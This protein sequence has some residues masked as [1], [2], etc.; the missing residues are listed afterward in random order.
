MA[1]LSA[2]TFLGPRGLTL[3]RVTSSTMHRRRFVV[4]LAALCALCFLTTRTPARGDQPLIQ[5]DTAFVSAA[6]DG[7]GWTIGNDLIRYALRLQGSTL[8]VQSIQDAQSGREWLRATGPDSFVIINALRV[9]IG[10]SDT[11]F[12]GAD[13]A[14]YQGGV[15][16]NL[17][18]RFT[19]TGLDITRSYVCYPG[20][21]VIETWT[22]FANLVTRPVVL[23]GLTNYSLAVENGTLHWLRGLNVPDAEGGSFSLAG[24][25]LD[26]GQIF[27][28][29]ADRR[30]SEQCVPWFGI[31]AEGTQ[32]FGAI[33][34]NGS[35]HLQVQRQGDHINVQ[36][37]LPVF[38][39]TVGGGA[40]MDTPHAIVGL[41]N[42][43]VPEVSMALRRFIDTGVRQGRQFGSYVT[44]NTWYSYGTFIDEASLT[45]EMDQAAAMGVEQFVVDAGWWF[46]INSVDASDFSRGWG[47]WQVDP[48]RFPSGLGALS[49]HAHDLGM[50]FGVWVEPE[51]VDRSTVG[52]P[53]L[54]QERFLATTGGVYDPSNPN[55]AQA[56]SAQICLADPAARQWVL[57][58]LV[59]F[60][61]EVHPDY[62]KWDNNFWIN[63]DRTGH[64]HGTEDGNFAHMQ[65]LQTILQQLRATYPLMDIEMCASGGNR[66]SLDLLAYSDATWMDDRTTPSS[67]VRHNLEGLSTIFPPAY[68]LAFAMDG[69]GEPVIDDPAYDLALVLRS[70]MPGLL[71]MSW[72]SGDMSEGTVT[73]VA[74]QI[75]LYKLIRPFLREGSAILLSPQ[76]LSTPDVPWTGWDVVEDIVPRTGEAVLFAFDAP[77]APASIVLRPRSLRADV[78]YDVES[79]DYGLLG[80]VSGAD[81]MAQGI[82][83]DASS[84]SHGHV[85]LLRVHADK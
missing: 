71:G 2:P 27:G 63:C 82:E 61:A 36:L 7:Q 11:L 10:G 9:D 60:I 55:N 38:S 28:L 84:L 17:R 79:A 48:E 77:D 45:T 41:T 42:S 34:W 26:D 33:L 37:G 39:T 20:A 6:D 65:G 75:S 70:R 3:A 53:G 78:T 24:G 50:R 23:S 19:P 30:S 52:K 83:V 73:E 80:S 66:I 15:R 44:Y 56:P 54:A 67:R 69:P 81:L 64:S 58:H 43:V 68:L 16:L 49:A 35:W 72:L 47:T 18:Y 62:L 29:G 46:H 14:P 85:I 5:Q 74:K 51:R 1:P 31:S 25:D 22:T 59:R 8:S 32:L 57:N 13:V 40:Q 76:Y 21:S 12:Q 4:L